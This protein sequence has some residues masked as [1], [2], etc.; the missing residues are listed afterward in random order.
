MAA[1]D[2]YDALG[3]A[4]SAS[5][6]EIQ[7]AFRR[8]AR[9]HHPDVNSGPGAE[10]RFKEVNEAHSVLSDP[11]T[12][13]RYDRFGPG[14]RQIPEGH[15]DYA[16]AAGGGARPRSAPRGDGGGGSVRVDT[17]GGAFG[18]FGD[19]GDLFS[20]L[21]GTPG[22]GPAGPIPGA[23]QEA[24]LEL[25]VEQAYRGGRRRVTLSGAGGP[26]TF[27][28]TIPAGV[29]D[30]QRIRL[31]GEGGQGTGSAPPGDLYLVVRI[32][33]HPHYRLDGRDIYVDLPLAPWDAAL[34]T[35]VP[36]QTPGGEAKVAV[37]AGSSSGRRLRLRGEGMPAPHGTPGDLYAVVR[38]MVPGR[39]TAGQRE[40]FEALARDSD[41][42]PRR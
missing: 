17:G 23:D 42:D 18:A 11:A 6:E 31:R 33:P 2:Y 38:I 10:E 15:E 19:L 34:G 20:G 16:A 4:R 27:E 12:R 13:K 24:E 21:S 9:R 37:P 5:Q 26:V 36:V 30:G 32:A 35:T 39:L 40:L 22:G 25:A 8:L 7:Q 14:F 1:R 3:V 41:F 29:R 28:V